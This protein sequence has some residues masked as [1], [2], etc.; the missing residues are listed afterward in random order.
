MRKKNMREKKEE[1]EREYDAALF[2]IVKSQGE[3]KKKESRDTIL[4]GSEARKA[5]GE[6]AGEGQGED[7]GMRDRGKAGRLA[8]E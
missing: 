2:T 5:K 1:R 4:A 7:E 8:L 6:C 3:K